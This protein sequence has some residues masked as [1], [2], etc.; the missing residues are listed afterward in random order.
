[1]SFFITIALLCNRSWN[2]GRWYLQ[3]FFN[4]SGFLRLFC[5][6]LLFLFWGFSCFGVCVCVSKWSSRLL[7]L[8]FCEVCWIFG[9]DYW[10]ITLTQVGEHWYS[11]RQE[12]HYTI[13]VYLYNWCIIVVCLFSLGFIFIRQ[14][15]NFVLEYTM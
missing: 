3:K 14:A 10:Y 7:F 13:V 6:L 4:D 12:T 9:G 11:T 15:L 5:F 2:L 8:N 1:M